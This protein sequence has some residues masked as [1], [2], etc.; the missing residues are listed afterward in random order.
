[1]KYEPHTP[2]NVRWMPWL[3]CRY[4][5]LVYL[6]NDATRKAIKQGHPAVENGEK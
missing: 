2:I 1:M 5:G 4:C 6:K 3:M